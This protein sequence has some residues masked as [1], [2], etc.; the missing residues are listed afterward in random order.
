MQQILYW[1]FHFIIPILFGIGAY[2]YD[3]TLPLFFKLPLFIFFI[4]EKFINTMTNIAELPEDFTIIIFNKIK[5]NYVSLERDES[6]K[7]FCPIFI[8]KTIALIDGIT[9]KANIEFIK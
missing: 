5:I 2:I 6:N 8:K 1:I 3:T 9:G 7:S 4:C